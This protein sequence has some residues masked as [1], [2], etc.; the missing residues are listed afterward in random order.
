MEINQIKKIFEKFDL[1]NIPKNGQSITDGSSFKGGYSRDLTGFHIAAYYDPQ[2]LY[3][4][5]KEPKTYKWL[6]TYLGFPELIKF[7]QINQIELN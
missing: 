3:P 2:A 1:K 7:N 5:L 4:S 6:I